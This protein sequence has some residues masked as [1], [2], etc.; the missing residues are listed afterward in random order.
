[1]PVLTKI[2]T[3]VIADDAITGDMLGASAYLANTATQNISGTYSESRM[4]TSDAYTLSGNATINSDVVLSTVKHD[5]DVVLTAGGAY[6][7]TGTGVLSGGSLATQT[8]TD[9][10]QL[11]G[12]L[13]SAVTGSPA[14]N[15]SNAT[16][17]P[18]GSVLNVASSTKTDT[19]FHATK[20]VTTIP[21]L[22][23]AIAPKF[24]SSKI[25]IMGHISWAMSGGN[26]G[27]PLK[28]FRNEVE[29]GS[30]ATAGGRPVGLADLNMIGFGQYYMDN[31]HVHFLDTPNTTSQITYSF[32]IVSRDGT[33]IYINRSSHDG[34]TEYTC[35]GS[36]TITVMEIAG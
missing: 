17:L 25:L 14:L 28:L 2:N 31:A 7:I 27:Y 24:V 32:R 6:T 33:T 4:Y 3:N 36:S 10:S 9:A 21:G 20:I 13:G 16:Q 18:T 5:D 23:V 26:S 1:M 15:L 11:S 8:N 35:R 12:V 30:G 29:V 19:S 34:D 22:A